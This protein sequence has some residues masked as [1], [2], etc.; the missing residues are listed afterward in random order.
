M[1]IC[2]YCGKEFESKKKSTKFCCRTCSN[3]SRYKART[4]YICDYC[5]KEFER[6]SSQVNG[7]HNIYC[8]IECQNKGTGIHNRGENH[9]RY[10]PNLTDED[11]EKTTTTLEYISWRRQVFNRDNYTCQHC[12]DSKGGNL[13]AHH[14]NSRDM[15]PQEK[16][17]VD[18]GI[19]LCD[20]CHRNFHHIYGYGH[21]TQQQYEEWSNKS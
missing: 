17:V 5:G 15:Y 20:K 1:K 2:E 4:T 21:N 9:P 13:N 19:T 18:N 14:K 16:Y 12:G 3:K 8:S 6:L 11:R 7:K 10:N